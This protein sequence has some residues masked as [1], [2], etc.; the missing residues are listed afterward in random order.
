MELDAVGSNARLTV[1]KVKESYAR[2]SHRD[3]RILEEYCGR[4]SPVKSLSRCR[5]SRLK[6]T[7]NCAT[8]ARDLRDD[9]IAR[10]I[11]DDDV[12]VNVV[13]FLVV[14]QSPVHYPH[15][16]LIRGDASVRRWRRG[17]RPTPHL[18]ERNRG[19]FR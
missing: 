10:A 19:R 8:W 3:V 18:R 6:R 1:Q 16:R 12:I 4:Q 5:D 17:R 2:D 11:L 13:L 15:G 9:C 7:P 14:D